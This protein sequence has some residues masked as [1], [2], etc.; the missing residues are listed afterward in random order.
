MA[1]HH[2]ENV[3]ETWFHRL[4]NS[5]K[6][7]LIGLIL[8]AISFPLI[9]WNEGRSVDRIKTLGDAQSTV[10]TVTAESFDPVYNAALIH[11]NGKADTTDIL[12][13]DLFG[14]KENALKI[15]RT[16]KMYQWEENTSSRSE[17]S[18][19]GGKK[20]EKTYSYNKVWSADLINSTNFKQSL[21]YPNP[22]TMPVKSQD[23]TSSNINVGAFE[24]SQ[25][26]VVQLSNYTNYP[27]TQETYKSMGS[28]SRRTYQLNGDHYFKGNIEDP[29]IGDV[30]VSFDIIRPHDVSVIGQQDNANIVPFT[31][32]KGQIQL[33]ESGRLSAD[34]M[35]AVAESKNKL[36]TWGLRGLALIFMWLGLTLVL[37]PVQIFSDVVPFIGSLVGVGI[38]LISGLIAVTLTSL[39]IALAW[40]FF[41]PLISLALIALCLGMVFLGFRL[42]RRGKGNI[43]EVSQDIQEDF[44]TPQA[45]LE[46]HS[47][48]KLSPLKRLKNKFRKKSQQDT[49]EVYGEQA[50]APMAPQPSAQAYIPPYDPSYS[51]PHPTAFHPQPQPHAHAQAQAYNPYE[52]AMP[53][54]EPQ[55]A[56]Q[57]YASPAYTPFTPAASYTPPAQAP[58]IAPNPYLARMTDTSAPIAPQSGSQSGQQSGEQSG[59]QS[60][61]QPNPQ[62]GLREFVPQPYMPQT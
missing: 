37:G 61:E 38:G 10:V 41:R 5:F 12:K 22:T 27:L 20:T 1:F 16:V 46:T 39:T 34:A 21:E 19:G 36:F 23:F 59:Q 35:I 40:L 9:W 13:D 33:I 2:S 45:A 8:F 14:V 50:Y 49:S 53:Q 29:Q 32:K 4:G 6:N 3:T 51:A 57:A 43:Q 42:M 7:V 54:V 25:P 44:Q 47:E 18:I 60:G 11:I 52:N 30:K 15:R 28:K 58:H 48:P 55:P 26:F 17:K 56:S 62:S 31:A 24:L